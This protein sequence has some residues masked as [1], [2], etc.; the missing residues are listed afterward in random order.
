M[1]T[2]KCIGNTKKGPCKKY[3]KYGDSCFWHQKDKELIIETKNKISEQNTHKTHKKPRKPRNTNKQ[4]EPKIVKLDLIEEL[5]CPV[6]YMTETEIEMKTFQ[7]KHHTCIEC[8]GKLENYTCPLCRCDIS[9]DIPI[10]KKMERIEIRRQERQE[11]QRERERRNAEIENGE[12][13]NGEMDNE[14][15]IMLLQA[16]ITIFEILRLRNPN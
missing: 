4:Y 11:R 3:A 16:G 6:C 8:L 15:F 2:N 1:S 13:E 10:E 5:V 9:I 12:I 7:C 14:T